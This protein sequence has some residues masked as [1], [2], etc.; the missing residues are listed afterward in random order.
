[1]LRGNR[2]K[3]KEFLLLCFITGRYNTA[4]FLAILWGRIVKSDI[5]LLANLKPLQRFQ[6]I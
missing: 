2:G 4:L 6:S 1:M 5:Y 3:I